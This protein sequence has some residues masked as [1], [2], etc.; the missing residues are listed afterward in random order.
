[1]ELELRMTE[2]DIDPKVLDRLDE[3]A[4][5]EACE[6]DSVNSPDFDGLRQRIYDR[7]IAELIAGQT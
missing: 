5:I 3:D 7:K 4:Y 1:M 6:S 2:D